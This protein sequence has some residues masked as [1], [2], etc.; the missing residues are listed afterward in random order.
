MPC[1]V[2]RLAACGRGI[3]DKTGDLHCPRGIRQLQSQHAIGLSKRL[4]HAFEE[5]V[6][7]AL[8]I[9]GAGPGVEAGQRVEPEFG[10]GESAGSVAVPGPLGLAA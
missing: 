3:G 5:F 4:A 2:R 8:D 6:L 1:C 10:K 9:A 7:D